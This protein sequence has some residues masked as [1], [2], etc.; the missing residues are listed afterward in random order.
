MA[1]TFDSNDRNMSDILQEIQ[2]GKTQL[3]DFQRPWVWDDNRIKALIASITN[4][5]P[6]GALM[7]LEYGGDEVRFKYRPFTGVTLNNI[8]PEW[9][10]LDGQ[11]RLTSIF[12]AMFSRE[13]VTTTN[14]KNDNPIKR[15]YYLNIAKCLNP[16]EDRIDAI[17]SIPEDKKIAFDFGR[18]PLL[19]YSSKEKEFENHVFPLNIVYDHIT[20]SKWQ[21][22]YY[23]FHAYKPEILE[24]FARFNAEVLVPIQ[25]Y[26]VPV[27]KLGKETPKE[28]V[29][30]VFE[31]VN[32]GGVSLSVFELMTA[33]YAA[34]DFQ[35]RNDWDARYKKFIEKTNLLKDV[36]G[37]DF[38][39]AL[40]LLSKYYK[41]LNNG[42]AVS[43]KRKDVLALP[44]SEYK[45]YADVLTQGF[46]S[47]AHFLIEQ[48]IFSNKDLPYSTQFIPLS[49]LFA[50]LGNKAHDSTV[51]EKL[52]HWYWCGVFGEMYGSAN[53]TRYANDAAEVIEWIDGKDIVPDTVSRAF[54]QPTR[55]LSLQSRQ[56][57]AYKG[58]MSLI[59]KAGSKDFVSGQPM[60]L[61]V[62]L[63]ESI[64]IHHI[65]PKAY[66]INQSL[67]KAKWNSIVNKTP[68]FFRTNKLLGGEAPSKYLQRIQN[69][70]HVTE[71][72]LREFVGSHKI[73]IEALKQDDFDR[74][75]IYRAQQILLLMGKAMGKDITDLDSEEVIKE[76][77]KSL[78]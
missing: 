35:L 16:A 44:L 46:I 33:S 40:T 60:D 58:I 42:E 15:F 43:C 30:Q 4:Y 63:E 24:R 71:D 26:K 32:T 17:V 2:N 14:G 31:N 51:K 69:N 66:C 73:D 12:S 23:K 29:C 38:L 65:F 9:L 75:I 72:K 70:K 59:L 20:C 5:Y 49:V 11:Q 47:A 57:A 77:G 18:K 74:H 53:E 3:P 37:K 61:T 56:S 45:K 34:D 50:I 54:F 36:E 13:P 25:T 67:S 21:N 55:L 48:C 1:G 78:K 28:A 39:T 8:K 41:H 10:V 64:D 27:I 7:F 6:M 68:L 19:D 62:Y 52:A 76:F 22:E